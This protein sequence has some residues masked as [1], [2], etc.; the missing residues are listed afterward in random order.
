MLS[1]LENERK[2]KLKQAL[3]NALGRDLAGY[4]LLHVW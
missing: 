2:D 3:Q 4:V 1:D